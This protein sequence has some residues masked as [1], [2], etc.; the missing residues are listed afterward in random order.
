MNANDGATDLTRPLP[1]EADASTTASDE[2]VAPFRNP[3]VQDADRLIDAMAL[4]VENAF[5]VF[6]Q[7]LMKRQE[8]FLANSTY[9]ALTLATATRR[10]L[11]ARLV[12]EEEQRRQQLFEEERKAQ[13]ERHF[14]SVAAIKS[15]RKSKLQTIEVE[16][17]PDGEPPADRYDAK[18][19]PEQLAAT[20]K[21]DNLI[22]RWANKLGWTFGEEG[23]TPNEIGSFRWRKVLAQIRWEH[24]MTNSQE[25]KK[26]R[27]KEEEEER[28]ARELRRQPLPTVYEETENSTI[29][30]TICDTIYSVTSN[31]VK[32]VLW[33][34]GYK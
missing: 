15:G 28:K 21:E 32:S 10:K 7:F 2:D 22:H 27:Q 34:M 26:R 23:M 12:W 24:R 8:A 31:L 9:K 25:E 5:P 11:R 1:E 6:R 30:S 19:T 20:E 3:S 14:S 16:M 17:L 4:G 18:Y 33:H 29:T 13:A